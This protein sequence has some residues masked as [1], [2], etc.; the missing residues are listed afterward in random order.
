MVIATRNLWPRHQSCSWWI[1]SVPEQMSPAGLLL[2]PMAVRKGS[3]WAAIAGAAFIIV[4]RER[5]RRGQ[6][7]L[8]SG[9]MSA[10]LPCPWESHF[11]LP[12]VQ[13]AAGRQE[14]RWGRS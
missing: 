7:L 4:P 5:Q 9:V 14:A 8:G 6:Q 12:M 3:P 13:L 10:F 11:F 1:A 2:P